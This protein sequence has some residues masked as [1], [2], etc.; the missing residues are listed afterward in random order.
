LLVFRLKPLAFILQRFAS[1]GFRSDYSCGAA[2]ASHHLPF[3][4]ALFQKV[5]FVLLF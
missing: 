4:L 2:V 3:P 1:R 5:L